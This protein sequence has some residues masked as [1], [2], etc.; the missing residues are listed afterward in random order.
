MNEIDFCPDNYSN[1]TIEMWDDIK[2]TLKVLL[3]NDNI[4][5]IHQEDF[6]IVVIKYAHND[7]IGVAYGVPNPEWI[8]PEEFEL[9]NDN[10]EKD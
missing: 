8:T 6:G 10:R 1:D 2:I 4:C 7:N 3:K 9:I 5:T